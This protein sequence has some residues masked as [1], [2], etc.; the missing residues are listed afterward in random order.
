MSA[1]AFC[2]AATLTAGTVWAQTSPPPAGGPYILNKQAIA[3]GAGRA[4]GGPYVLT[5][6]VAQP[7]VDPLP[8]T[9]GPYQLSGGFH[10]PLVPRSGD[11]FADG[12]EG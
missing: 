8:A 11:V 4:T 5:G 10:T 12:F 3:G 2:L 6:T 1:L 7:A 9:G